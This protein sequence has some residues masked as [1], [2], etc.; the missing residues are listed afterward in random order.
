MQTSC[1]LTWLR[2][3]GRCKGAAR[4]V[5]GPVELR[6]LV[7]QPTGVVLDAARHLVEGGRKAADLILPETATWTSS[8]PLL[9]SSAAF[10]NSESGPVMRLRK[11]WPMRT[12]VPRI[13]AFMS[14]IC[15][16]STLTCCRSGCSDIPAAVHRPCPP[17]WVSEVKEIIA[18][19]GLDFQ[20]AAL[21]A[22]FHKVSP[23]RLAGVR[24][25]SCARALPRL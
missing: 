22:R 5:V 21:A 13:T 12:P 18:G 4:L 11:R 9:M 16:H 23:I 20:D 8:R 17:G 3:P 19:F 25:G 10:D 2:P 15:S 14:A 24:Q 1:R 6:S 7:F